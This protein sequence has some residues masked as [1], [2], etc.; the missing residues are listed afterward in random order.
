MDDKLSTICPQSLS[1]VAGALC[2]RELNT[3][4]R[5]DMPLILQKQR[6]YRRF[7]GQQT[8]RREKNTKILKISE[9]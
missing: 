8:L 5:P 2:V 7:N 6:C 1:N 3:G 4:E 9:F